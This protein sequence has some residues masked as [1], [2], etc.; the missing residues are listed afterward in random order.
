MDTTIAV[1][2]AG[3]AD[4]PDPFDQMGRSDRPDFKRG[5]SVPAS[6][7]ILPWVPALPSALPLMLGEDCI[8]S[9]R[10][11][12]RAKPG[13]LASLFARANPRSSCTA[14]SAA[15]AVRTSSRA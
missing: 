2:H 10:P 9:R 1:A 14:M 11:R 5:E 6:N 7:Q 12:L 3:G 15:D 4:L 8:H 13:R